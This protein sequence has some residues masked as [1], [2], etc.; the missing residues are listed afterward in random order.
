MKRKI[1]CEKRWST[2][3]YLELEIT[4]YEY[5]QIQNDYDGDPTGFVWDEGRFDDMIEIDE[6]CYDD[7]EDYTIEE[8][9]ED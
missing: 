2:I 7:Q 5:N 4:E 6:D 3:Q 9:L 1:K 8:I